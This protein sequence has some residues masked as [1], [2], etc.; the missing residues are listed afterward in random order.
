MSI[1]AD[2]GVTL[3]TIAGLEVQFVDP[4]SVLHPRLLGHLP[5]GTHR[6]ENGVAVVLTKTGRCVVTDG[7][8]NHVLLVEGIVHVT[9]E[10]QETVLTQALAHGV[11]GLETI[12]QTKL[13]VVGLTGGLSL[14]TIVL[15][16]YTFLTG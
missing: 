16:V 11:V 4:G 3:G 6:P 2:G 9:E 5:H 15:V 10:G 12:L 1:V 13:L 14:E 8:V 7:S